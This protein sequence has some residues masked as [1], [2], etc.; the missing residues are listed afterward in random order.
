MGVPPGIGYSRDEIERV[1]QTQTQ[2]QTQMEPCKAQLCATP[3]MDICGDWDWLEII[4]KVTYL[5]LFW[6]EKSNC[7]AFKLSDTAIV[8]LRTTYT[9]MYTVCTPKSFELLGRSMRHIHFDNL[10]MDRLCK[11]SQLSWVVVRS[12]M[13]SRVLDHAGTAQHRIKLPSLTY[14]TLRG[15]C[16]RYNQPSRPI[17]CSAALR[18]ARRS[19]RSACRYSFTRLSA[20][21]VPPSVIAAIWRKILNC[22]VRP[23]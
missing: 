3:S 22:G 11:C 17:Y 14:C 2:I 16:R 21:I 6:Y 13:S 19:L 18:S 8:S 5:Q 7:L 15:W 12:S 1:T 23:R 20:Q 9:C 10:Y 4:S